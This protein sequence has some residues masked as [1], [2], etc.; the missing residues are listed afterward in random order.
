MLRVFP[1]KW[2]HFLGSDD[3]F[4]E[5]FCYG[6]LGRIDKNWIYLMNN[7]KGCPWSL[8]IWTICAYSRSYSSPYYRA[9]YTYYCQLT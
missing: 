7:W 8:T 6:F 5:M 1:C 2:A 3:S 4:D 9:T